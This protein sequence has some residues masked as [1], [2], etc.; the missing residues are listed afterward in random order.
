ALSSCFCARSTAACARRAASS[1]SSSL[2]SAGDSRTSLSEPS[3]GDES[4]RPYIPLVGDPRRSGARGHRIPRAE[5]AQGPIEV[6]AARVESEIL[7]IEAKQMLLGHA[8]TR[9]GIL[10]GVAGAV[11]SSIT[12]V[13]LA[14]R[15]P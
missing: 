4:P 11:A 13:F 1:A 15:L 7:P 3:L 9:T 12:R 5:L 8:C 2:C 14:D 6:P 10:L